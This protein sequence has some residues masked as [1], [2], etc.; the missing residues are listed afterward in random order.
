M[1]RYQPLASYYARGTASDE[2]QAS[3]EE[4]KPT[5]T[6]IHEDLPSHLHATHI[7][8]VHKCSS[9]GGKA[10]TEGAGA[11]ACLAKDGTMLQ[12]KLGFKHMSPSKKG[13]VPSPEDSKRFSGLNTVKIVENDPPRS[14]EQ[15]KSTNSWNGE[16][17]VER[18]L[19]PDL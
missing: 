8:G 3:Y 4:F 5:S 15:N 1:L 14:G 12:L 17:L 11:M 7:R 10:R 6:Q 16:E 19:S 18:E 2:R 13:V 9:D